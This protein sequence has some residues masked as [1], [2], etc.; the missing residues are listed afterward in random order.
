MNLRRIFRVAQFAAAATATVTGITLLVCWHLF[1]FPEHLLAPVPGGPVVFEREGR[2]LLGLTD[3]SSQ[4]TRPARLPD[5]SPWLVKATI[6]IEDHRFFEH[7]GIDPIAVLR[8]AGQNLGS[9]RVVSGASTLTMQLCRMLDPRP[10]T[11]F[12]KSIESLRALQLECRIDKVEILERYL[13]MAPYG[14][15]IRGVEAASRI[16]FHKSAAD[17]C[18]SE[19]ALLAGLPQSPT[20]LRPDRYPTRTLER[21]T[22][23]L[24]AMYA[25]GMIGEEEHLTAAAQPL[26]VCMFGNAADRWRSE[27]GR[28]VAWWALARRPEG[29]RTTIDLDLQEIVEGMV[30]EQAAGLP[31]GTDLAVVVIHVPSGEIRALVGSADFEDQADGQVNGALAWRSPG[32]ALKPFLFAAAF[33][34][35]R[36]G[37]DSPV[38]D[39]PMDRRG[40]RPTNFAAGYAGS[41][42]A[43]EALRSSLNL[44]A[45]RITE[46][47]GISRCVGILE[48]VGLRLPRDAAARGGLAL[49]T[50]ALEVRLL[51]LTN[52]YATLARQGVHRP[53]RLFFDERDS[54]RSALC[55]DVA[56]VVNDILSVDH[57]DPNNRAGLI[58][59]PQKWFTWKT[60]TSSGYRDAWAVGHNLEFAIGVWAGRFSGAGD[61]SY[62]GATAAEP[63]LAALFTHPSLATN[64]RPPEPP[65]IE[66]RRPL[67][68]TEEALRILSPSPG[69]ILLAPDGRAVVR[70]GASRERPGSWFLNG[71]LLANEEAARLL[72]APGSYELVRVES[73]GDAATAR[74]TVR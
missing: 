27:D 55:A 64:E 22:M 73:D 66:V 10:R 24:D 54:E 39:R 60:G 62:V 53:A 37:P 28:H 17:L 67:F 59:S 57:R 42:T 2:P 25:K 65:V 50:G 4:W 74:F 31:R 48:S 26:G 8:A 41:I 44:P 29:G 32:S 56:A 40:Y 14:G 47:G 5:I 20:R 68:D 16:W 15:N 38:P 33:S 11:L 69:T 61:P 52:A 63:L 18:L 46:A 43:A 30:R 1:P 45:L 58:R 13:T 35:G 6:A 9:A 71:R 36:L 21:R 51:D 3:Q 49:A 19:A 72:L 7:R 34:A 12:A 23:V 70:P